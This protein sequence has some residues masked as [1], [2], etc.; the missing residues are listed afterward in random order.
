LP[1]ELPALDSSLA[2]RSEI[3]GR[4]GNSEPGD[5]LR[6]GRLVCGAC[7]VAIFRQRVHCLPSGAWRAPHR[8]GRASRSI[9]TDIQLPSPDA[10]SR[11]HALASGRY[12][13]VLAPT[14]SFRLG[15][16]QGGALGGFPLLVLLPFPFWRS[17]SRPRPGSARERGSSLSFRA[18]APAM[19]SRS[20]SFRSSN[21]SGPTSNHIE[22]TSR[23]AQTEACRLP[24]FRASFTPSVARTPPTLRYHFTSFRL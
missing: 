6:V 4:E 16:V 8:H 18:F 21:E 12:S 24:L 19:T 23:L 2:G 5:S 7:P 9:P 22:A 10:G 3:A 17:S 20:M 14:K 15:F 11:R 1:G 13:P